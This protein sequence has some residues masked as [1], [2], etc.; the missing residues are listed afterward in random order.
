[1]LDPSNKRREILRSMIV[2]AIAGMVIGA[3]PYLL[4]ML[5]GSLERLARFFFAGEGGALDWLEPLPWMLWFPLVSYQWGLLGTAVGGATAW[6]LVRANARPWVLF[7]AVLTATSL[8]VGVPTGRGWWWG[9]HVSEV[10]F[11]AE[12]SDYAGPCPVTV[13]FVARI[14]VKGGPGTVHYLIPRGK[15]LDSKESIRFESSGTKEVTTD[16][17]FGMP[18]GKDRPISESGT[19]Q[20]QILEPHEEWMKAAYR[21]RCSSWSRADR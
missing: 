14:T 3:L 10:S 8:A 4:F 5:S 13:K 20:M 7:S 19:L 16:M 18:F 17:T 21:I 15:P 11:R 12:P 9:F 2:G 6:L 1:M